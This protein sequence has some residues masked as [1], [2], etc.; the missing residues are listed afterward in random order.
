[1]TATTLA[2][3][4]SQSTI[5]AEVI[6]LLNRYWK[7]KEHEI[8]HL[9]IADTTIFPDTLPPQ[10]TLVTL[11]EWAYDCGV[12]GQ[13]LV[14]KE[15]GNTWEN[16]PWLQVAYWMLHAYPERCWEKQFGCIDSYSIRLKNWD[17]RLWQHAWV[18]RIALFLR[19]WASYS[20][21]IPETT[22]FGMLPKAELL[23]THDVDA[24]K[25]TIA[26]RLKQAIF[27]G[28]NAGRLVRKGQFG[29]ALT[30]LAHAFRFLVSND[31]YMNIPYLLKLETTYKVKSVFHFYA[32]KTSLK[33]RL[34][35][36][37]IDPGYALTDKKINKIFTDLKQGG[38][39]IGLHPSAF[40]WDKPEGIKIQKMDLEKAAG[41]SVTK[42]RQHWLRFSWQKTWE[43]QWDAGLTLDSTLGF[44]D[45]C[46]F[47]NS[48]ALR[49]PVNGA[50]EAHFE[51]VPMFLMDSHLYDYAMLNPIE[52]TQLIQYW[53]KELYDVAG[54]G[55]IIWHTHVCGK[56]YGW[57]AGYETLLQY[58]MELNRHDE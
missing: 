10:L 44:N 35:S 24:I 15:W 26:I 39:E 22:L 46:G 48:A 53:L 34:G 40:T 49:M 2:M 51:S 55:S 57:A 27:N 52:R 54:V 58:W 14:P 18:N 21:K 56:D 50:T 47:R 9:A 30:K 29:N 1:M 13:L 43:A 16:V 17:E 36:L 7:N 31:D 4:K 41:C 11:P 23:L 8:A 6:T 45:R 32:G 33:R 19:R 37:L 20:Q 25:K 12:N 42:L 38:W 5:H 28:F 3:E